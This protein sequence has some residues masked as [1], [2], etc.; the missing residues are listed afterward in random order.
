M[1]SS[2]SYS[3]GQL[4]Q[5][6]PSS[7]RLLSQLT[8]QIYWFDNSFER[9]ETKLRTKNIEANEMEAFETLPMS[10]QCQK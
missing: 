4:P 8:V 5:A 10:S 1:T 7:E 9:L 3:M 2:F 6:A